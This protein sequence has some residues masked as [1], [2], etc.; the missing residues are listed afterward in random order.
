MSGASSTR[1]A[2]EFDGEGYWEHG[3]EES[4]TPIQPKPA[5][6][7]RLAGQLRQ[8]LRM[9]RHTTDELDVEGAVDPNPDGRARGRSDGGSASSSVAGANF[10]ARVYGVRSVEFVSDVKNIVF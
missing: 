5:S 8:E 10:E 7:L 4:P 6:L 9:T 1:C 3:V 2:G